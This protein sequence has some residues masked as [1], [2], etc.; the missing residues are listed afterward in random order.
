MK[1]LLVID[2]VRKKMKESFSSNSY[3]CLACKLVFI[4]EV[5]AILQVLSTSALVNAKEALLIVENNFKNYVKLC[6]LHCYAYQW[7]NSFISACYLGKNAHA[8]FNFADFSLV[9]NNIK[10]K[11]AF[12]MQLKSIRC[13][14]KH[15]LNF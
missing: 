8:V 15:L 10:L 9:V 6:F 3:S 14:L 4:S 2:L 5:F 12:C 11:T 7:K 1:A 13:N